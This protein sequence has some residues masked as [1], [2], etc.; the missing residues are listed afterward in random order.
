M[1]Y[2][3]LNVNFP[4]ISAMFFLFILFFFEIITIIRESLKMRWDAI[5]I[6]H[7]YD[8]TWWG[9]MGVSFSFG[10]ISTFRLH[11]VF[12]LLEQNVGNFGALEHVQEVESSRQQWTKKRM[13]MLMML[14]RMRR[15]MDGWM[16]WWW[17]F[18]R[19]IW[20]NMGTKGKTHNTQK[21]TN[22][23]FTFFHCWSWISSWI[24]FAF[25]SLSYI[26]DITT[27]KRKKK[28]FS[29]Y[30]RLFFCAASFACSGT[31]DT[32]MEGKAE[33]S[34]H[35]LDGWMDKMRWN[36]LLA[37]IACLLLQKKNF[38]RFY[39]FSFSRLQSEIFTAFH[40]LTLRFKSKVRSFSSWL[41]EKSSAAA[42]V[43][44]GSWENW[45]ESSRDVAEMKISS[46]KRKKKFR[47][48]CWSIEFSR[49]SHK[50]VERK[51]SQTQA[52]YLTRHGNALI[53][54]QQRWE[55]KSRKK[56]PLDAFSPLFRR[57]SV[58]SSSS[59]R[60]EKRKMKTALTH[61]YHSLLLWQRN[62]VEAVSLLREI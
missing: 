5:S 27:E 33:K 24:F 12:A 43:A 36:S 8:W 3:K 14:M 22:K 49:F 32:L 51:C 45:V 38:P 30:F 42:S 20:E 50:T 39:L 60:A 6:V 19:R 7:E 59:F 26:R 15:R 61:F 46:E 4:L 25:S 54:R 53:C 18:E 62:W 23:N 40:A 35:W 31:H 1:I 13:K 16:N 57:R 56:A 41:S 11:R 47:N 55:V 10:I 9:A 44:S 48:F 58:V 21:N 34:S 2:D 28:S 17:E 37:F 29:L 52:R